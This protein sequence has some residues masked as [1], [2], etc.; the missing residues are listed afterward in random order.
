MK[1]H[2]LPGKTEVGL[3]LSECTFLVLFPLF[4]FLC[5]CFSSARGE[6]GGTAGDS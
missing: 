1:S 4:A 2:E 5:S 6:S 3:C